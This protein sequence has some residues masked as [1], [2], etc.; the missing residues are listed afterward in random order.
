M[1][2]CCGGRYLSLHGWWCICVKITHVHVLIP[3]SKSAYNKW[4]VSLSPLWLWHSALVLQDASMDGNWVNDTQAS[5]LLLKNCICITISRKYWATEDIAKSK[6][7]EMY[8]YFYPKREFSKES[9][10]SSFLERTLERFWRFPWQNVG[11]GRPYFLTSE[12]RLLSVECSLF[13]F[14]KPR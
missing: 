8:T 9:G 6:K 5:V 1:Y 7:S 12:A 10:C 3:L 13:K 14:E 2:L 4:I 11:C